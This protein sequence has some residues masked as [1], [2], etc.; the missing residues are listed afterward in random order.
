MAP[1]IAST[2]ILGGEYKLSAETV[3]F[4]NKKGVSVKYADTP[5]EVD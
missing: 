1:T 5:L 3:E 2:V 4:L